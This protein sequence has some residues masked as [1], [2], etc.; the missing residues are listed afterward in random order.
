[1]FTQQSPPQFGQQANNNMYNG[2]GMNLNVPMAA[3]SSNMGQ[4]GNQMMSSMNSGPGGS[5]ANMGPEQVRR[6]QS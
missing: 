6:I 2:N 3:N 4:M 5:M 1:M